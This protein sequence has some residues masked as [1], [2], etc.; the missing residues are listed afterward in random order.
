MFD[1][2]QQNPIISFFIALVPVVA[3][4]WKVMNI[5]FVKPR[6]FRIAVLEKNVEE[7]RKELQKQDS[8]PTQTNSNSDFKG[9]EAPLIEVS[10]QS[11]VIENE[12]PEK[13]ERIMESTS[14]L[15]NMDLFYESWKDKNLTE[16]QR[17]QFEKN[18]VGQKVVWVATFSSVSEEKDGYLWVSL[19]S[20]DEKKFGVHVIAVFDSNHKEVLL[21]INKNE[22]V[23][24]S[25]TIDSFSLS[26]LIRKCNLT[27]KT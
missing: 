25:G 3:G 16:L 5:L 12:E 27:R 17:D 6:D 1:I 8:H 11:I 20:K 9:K 24:I 23:T 26:P 13:F 22:L 2:I 19:T 7:I 18:Y 10:E 21:T 14:L 15:N 4:L